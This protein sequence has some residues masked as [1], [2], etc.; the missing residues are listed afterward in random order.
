MPNWVQTWLYQKFRYTKSAEKPANSRTFHIENYKYN[1]LSIENVSF[2]EQTSN[3]KANHYEALRQSSAGW[4][5]GEDCF[6]FNGSPSHG[7]T[8]SLTIYAAVHDRSFHCIAFI[9]SSSRLLP[10]LQANHNGR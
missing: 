1:S 4:K 5:T 10:H 7:P 9:A 2:G 8:P 6:A 3:C